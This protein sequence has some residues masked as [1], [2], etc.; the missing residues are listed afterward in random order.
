MEP[1][2]G[3]EPT[4]YALRMRCLHRWTVSFDVVFLFVSLLLSSYLHGGG[5]GNHQSRVDQL[6]RHPLSQPQALVGCQRQFNHLH[7]SY[8]RYGIVIPFQWHP[9]RLPGIQ[10]WNRALPQELRKSKSRKFWFTGMGS[11]PQTFKRSKV[12]LR[13]SGGWPT[14]SSADIHT[15]LQPPTSQILLVRWTWICSA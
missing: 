4:T 15:P 1:R 10:K 6:H 7:R 12:T 5:R 3:F 11:G 9:N 2:I 13:I 8:L 14:N